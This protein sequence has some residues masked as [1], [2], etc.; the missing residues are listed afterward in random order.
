MRNSIFLLWQRD[1]DCYVAHDSVTQKVFHYGEIETTRLVED[2]EQ[3]GSAGNHRF[4]IPGLSHNRY[5]RR[6]G[7]VGRSN[8]IKS[9]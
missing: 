5:G 2:R 7:P 4:E 1:D 6:H 8:A 3:K 9:G